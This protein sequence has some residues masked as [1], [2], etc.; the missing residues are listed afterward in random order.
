MRVV[1]HKTNAL[2]A[3]IFMLAMANEG[4]DTCPMEG[5]DSRRVKKLLK[6]PYGAEI[7][8]VVACGIR[9]EG[10]VW[11]NRMRVPFEEVYFKV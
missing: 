6:L 1:V 9:E 4:Y 2:A 3:Q 10:G 5:F 11:G 7:T 8:M